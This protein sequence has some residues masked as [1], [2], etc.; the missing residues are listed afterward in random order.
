M[1]PRLSFADVES[2]YRASPTPSR[3]SQD[4]LRDVIHRERREFVLAHL[5]GRPRTL[6]VEVGAAYGDFLRSL[7]GFERLV[8]IEP[9]EACNAFHAQAGDLDVR[10]CMLEEVPVV[11]PDLIGAAD[12]VVASHVL[13]HAE[14]PRR[15]VRG[16]TALARPGGLVQVEVPSIEA[17][18]ECDRPRYQTLHVGH[19]SQ[20]SA[21]TLTRL[22]VT[23]GLQP[24]A[25]E[26]TAR[27]DYPV[28]RALFERAPEPAELAALFER[29]GAGVDAAARDA[30]H[31]LER[32]LGP[33]VASTL[34]WGCGQDLVDVLELFDGPGLAELG[35]RATLVDASPDK[36]G[37]AV[38]GLPIHAPEA[39]DAGRVVSIVVTSRSELIQADIDR[40]ARERVPGARVVRLFPLGSAG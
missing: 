3:A 32:A 15:F 14:D 21:L 34:V 23:E 24:V 40:A 36:Q 26:T 13:E 19:V 35:R 18:A 39:V 7:P 38:K 22:C 12:L 31:T 1:H 28:V 9:S 20:F 11:A 33:D 17:M 6:A 4:A 27:H 37:R 30:Q 25:L 29:H 16:L 5:E 8:G 10:A 2:N